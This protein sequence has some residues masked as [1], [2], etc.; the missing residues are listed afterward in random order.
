MVIGDGKEFYFTFYKPRSLFIKQMERYIGKPK[1]QP[2][3]FIGF[4]LHGTS[5]DPIESQAHNEVD[6]D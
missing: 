4:K 2:K 6:M 5:G 3:T 1:G